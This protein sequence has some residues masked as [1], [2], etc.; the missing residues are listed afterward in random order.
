MLAWDSC[1]LGVRGPEIGAD[2]GTGVPK[3]DFAGLK[4]GLNVMEM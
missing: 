3:M 1:D 4:P 2:R